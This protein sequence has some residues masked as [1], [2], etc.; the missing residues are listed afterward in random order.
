MIILYGPAGANCNYIC[1]VINKV[2]PQIKQNIVY[3]Y[4]GTHA[5]NI[6][7][8]RQQEDLEVIE[9]SLDDKKYFG[10]IFHYWEDTYEKLLERNN[11]NP[12]QIYIDDYKEMVVINWFE[13]FLHNPTTKRDEMQSQQWIKSQ[14][15]HWEK[16]TNFVGER[17]VTHWIYKIYSNAIKE[18]ENNTFFKKKFNFG[19]MYNSFELTQK[20]F[21]KFDIEYTETM[22][23][24]WK[25][26]Q[27]IPI[28]SWKQIKD[29]IETPKNLK[30]FYQRG[31]AIALE[32]L[33]QKM[34]EE[35]CWTQMSVKLQ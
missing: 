11:I 28:D 2:D 20:E 29:N 12:F 26:S 3:H 21:K 32:G 24:N 16:Y 19:S 25:D 9:K 22:Y 10:C 6:K 15:T 13:K 14:K 18:F 7:V 31:I 5:G 27:K 33:K 4:L 34:S 30:K 8:V 23:N 17:A 1:L 35:D